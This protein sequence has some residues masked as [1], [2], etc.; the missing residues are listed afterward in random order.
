[1][2]KTL[3]LMFIALLALG[4]FAC[5]EKKLTEDDLKKAEATLFK[6]DGSINEDVAPGVAKQYCKFVEQHPDDPAAALWL[7]HAFEVNVLTKNVKKSVDLCDQL[8]E[9][10][11]Q[12]EWTPKAMYILGSF[13]YEDYLQDLDK[14]RS[15]YE[16]VI[17][18]Y[19]DSDVIP[20]VEASIKYLGMTPEEIMGMINLSQMDVEEGSWE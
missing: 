7:Y 13:I 5:G 3:K 15:L 11:S 6:E 14:A 12:S 18:E 2:K 1:M 17:E 19:P 20:S 10:Y 9:K 16:R 8:V 4:L